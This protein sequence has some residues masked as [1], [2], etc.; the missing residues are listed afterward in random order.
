M[1]PCLAWKACAVGCPPSSRHDLHSWFRVRVRVRVPFSGCSDNCY[2][3]ESAF[4]MARVARG[5]DYCCKIMDKNDFSIWD[6]LVILS[7][8]R[9]KS[10]GR[11]HRTG[12]M[13]SRTFALRPCRHAGLVRHP[14]PA[15]EAQPSA[16]RAHISRPAEPEPL[17]RLTGATAFFV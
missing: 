17:Q 3:H 2:P 1:L 13:F 8:F 4:R 11:V 5:V 12:G 6:E 9:N 10:S 15:A 14:K 16:H 7:T